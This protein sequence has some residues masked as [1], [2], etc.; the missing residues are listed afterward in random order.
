MIYSLCEDA[1][2]DS[3]N[4][5]RTLLVVV[6]Y[7]VDQRRQ[8]LSA[9]H[10]SSGWRRKR[11]KIFSGNKKYSENKILLQSQFK[12]FSVIDFAYIK[13]IFCSEISSPL[14]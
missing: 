12:R 5:N 10:F 6:T 4:G 14:M 8:L 9:I 2:G 3:G 13:F 1:R 11:A 7:R